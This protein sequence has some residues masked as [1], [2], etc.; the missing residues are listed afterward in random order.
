MLG[1]LDDSA[2]FDEYTWRQ[3]IPENSYWRNLHDW[4][5]E[6]L[7]VEDFE[8]LYSDIGRPSV[9]PV[10]T[11]LAILIQL[12]KGY[13]DREMEEE[14]RFDDRVKF[15]LLVKRNFGGIDSVTLCRHRGLLFAN[16]YGRKLLVRTVSQAL[17]LGIF[18]PG[19]RA[20]VDSFI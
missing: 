7:R 20:V 1:Q 14:T 4:A 19:S 18:T 15:A 2:A 10:H 5:R 13:S 6:S 8:P 12:E 11:F 9:C 3:L 16:D 17:E